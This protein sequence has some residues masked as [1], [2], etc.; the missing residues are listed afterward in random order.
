ML[1][2]TETVN[3]ASECRGAGPRTKASLSQRKVLVGRGGG[4]VQRD[5]GVRLRREVPS[6]SELFGSIKSSV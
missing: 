3:K 1:C 2:Q 6:H 5:R 4:G